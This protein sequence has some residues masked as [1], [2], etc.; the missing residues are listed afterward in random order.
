MAYLLSALKILLFNL[1][2]YQAL[3]W[4]GLDMNQ[5]RATVTQTLGFWGS[6]M[7]FWSAHHMLG[8]GFFAGFHGTRRWVDTATPAFVW[9]LG[10]V[11]LWAIGGVCMYALA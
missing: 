5:P 9:R 1:A 7:F 10:G 11:L 8:A 2:L 4:F 3:Q 6:V